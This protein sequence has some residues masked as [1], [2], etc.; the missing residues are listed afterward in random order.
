MIF[1][2]LL[3]L[4]VSSSIIFTHFVLLIVG[5]KWKFSMKLRF[6]KLTLKY[7]IFLASKWK[8]THSLL[9]RKCSG[10]FHHPAKNNS[11]EIFYKPSTS[12][13]SKLIITELNEFYLKIMKDIVFTPGLI[14]GLLSQSLWHHINRT[15]R[16]YA[17]PFL[18]RC[19]KTSF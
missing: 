8:H 10:L 16:P 7:A 19:K 4:G 12:F 6:S 13:S 3:M 14:V 2:S 9:S 11:T 15:E 5:W 1:W 17:A 18:S